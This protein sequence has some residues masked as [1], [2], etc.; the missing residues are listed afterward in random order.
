MNK[1]I[2][3]WGGVIVGIVF[4]GA[5]ILYWVTPAGQLPTYVPGYLAGSTTVHFKH[6]L[7]A[8]LLGLLALAFAWFSTAKPKSPAAPTAQ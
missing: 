8:G 5:A 1:N 4:I 6:G 3:V 2:K 7:A